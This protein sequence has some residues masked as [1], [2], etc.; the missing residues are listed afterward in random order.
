MRMAAATTPRCR[1]TFMRK[2]RQPLD[3]EGEVEL[4]GLLEALALVLAQDGVDELLRL[5][6]GERLVGR[7]PDLPVDAEDAAAPPR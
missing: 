1:K 5:L 7:R 4:V 2:R 3:P 6:G